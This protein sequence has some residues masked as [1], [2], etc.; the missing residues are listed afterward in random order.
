MYSVKM[1]T[2][3]LVTILETPERKI[4]R[5]L[6]QLAIANPAKITVEV[7][8]QVQPKVVKFKGITTTAAPVNVKK[9][10]KK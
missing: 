8:K 9:T 3:E 4:A 2:T 10:G 7:T 1:V 6:M 5:A